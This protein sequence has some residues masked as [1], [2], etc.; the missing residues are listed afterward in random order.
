MTN[1][2]TPKPTYDAPD[3]TGGALAAIL[4]ELSI[5]EIRFL[6]ARV[7]TSTDKDAATAI[8]ISPN[9]VKK[10]PA[11]R[12]EL[13]RTA[14]KLMAQDGIVTAMHLR[15]RNLAKAMAVKVKGLESAD[16]RI[17]QNVATEVIEW[18]LGKATQPTEGSSTVN[19]NVKHAEELTDDQLARIASESSHGAAEA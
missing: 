14:R 3:S 5:D 17:R 4:Q 10:W 16:E 7:D 2:S 19:V 9:T 15:R 1:Q 6:I 8:G 13:I 12:K 11:E 18:E